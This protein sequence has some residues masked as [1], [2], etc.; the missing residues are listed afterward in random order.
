MNANRLEMAEGG[1]VDA[2]HEMM[3]DHVALE[4]INAFHNKEPKAFRDAFHVLVAHTLG[5]MQVSENEE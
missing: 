4:G 1:E 2:D 3:M 5:Q